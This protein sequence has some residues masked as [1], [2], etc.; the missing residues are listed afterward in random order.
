M[1]ITKIFVFCSINLILAFVCAGQAHAQSPKTAK[2]AFMSN[3]DGNWEIYQMNPN[4]SRQERLTRNNVKDFSPVWSPNGEQILFVSNRNGVND[5]YVMNANG[6]QV[7]RVFRESSRRQDPTWAPDGERIAFH[8]ETPHWSIQTATIHGAGVEEVA[9]A[10]R[11]GGNPSWSPDGN[12]IAFVGNDPRHIRIITLSSGRVRTFLP[13]EM[14]WMYTPAWSPSGDRL[15]FT[16]YRWGIH[17]KSA[18]FVANRDGSRLRQ[19]SKRESGR[20]PAW[21][22]DGDKIVYTDE[23]I[24]R[25]GQIVVVDVE[26]GRETQ[27][28]HRGWN[29]GG[30]WF[31]PTSLSVTPEPHLLTTTWGK[32][33][34]D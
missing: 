33:K 2:I 1:K 10:I 15:A 12:E 29:I 26:T 30:S 6:S 23:T 22:A 3:R 25:D 32:I 9:A 5:L 24:E 17:G 16:W 8:A 11:Q 34:A 14:P 27:L 13:R 19:I 21:S 20:Y 4:G 28:T 7:Q 18:V 31:D